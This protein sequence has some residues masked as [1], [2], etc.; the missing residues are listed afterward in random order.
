MYKFIKNL[1]NLNALKILGRYSQKIAPLVYQQAHAY[2]ML[3]YKDPCP[4][5]VIEAMFV[6]YQ[7]YIQF[8]W[9][10]GTSK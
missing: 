9:I 4:N 10:A 3:K 1:K 8:W 7:F 6:V 5:S 2:V